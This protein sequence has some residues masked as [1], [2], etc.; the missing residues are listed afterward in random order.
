MSFVVARAPHVLGV[1]LWIG[2]VSMVTTV[3]LPAVRKLKT[4]EE[5]V[6]FFEEVEGRFAIQARVT[7][8]LTGLTGFY[9]LHTLHAWSWLTD[10]NHW[11][12]GAMFVV[13]LV[14]TLILFVAEPLFL[15]ALFHT[16]SK[17]DPE[18]TFAIVHRMHI[19][20]LTISLIT[21]FAGVAGAHGL[22]AML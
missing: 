22:F 6:Q 4:P 20:L 17:R 15:H 19:F 14:F 7:T 8:L 1:V 21:V 2:G 13:W 9:M 11:Y 16:R 12:I 3:L 10:P 18:G 5:R